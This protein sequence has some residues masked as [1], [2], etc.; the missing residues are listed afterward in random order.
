MEWPSASSS[1]ATVPGTIPTTGPTSTGS[2]ISA[3]GRTPTR[4]NNAA[5]RERDPSGQK[6]PL[7]ETNETIHP[8]VRRRLSQ[9]VEVRGDHNRTRITYRPA[10]LPVA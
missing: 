9:Q 10:G 7:V 1:A 4:F 3:S 8:S 2:P 6:F 5:R